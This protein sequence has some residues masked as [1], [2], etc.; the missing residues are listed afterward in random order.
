MADDPS[1]KSKLR[2]WPIPSLSTIAAWA[3]EAVIVGLSMA[4]VVAD[5]RVAYE[6]SGTRYLWVSVGLGVALLSANVLLAVGCKAV[7]H[8]LGQENVVQAQRRSRI[9]RV[10][11]LLP[12][13]SLAMRLARHAAF[14]IVA[15]A[16]PVGTWGFLKVRWAMQ[17]DS[18]SMF[19]SKNNC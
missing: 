9:A 16:S 17:S 12:T 11:S 1:G 7:L 10:R 14:F 18:R 4:T 8:D 13:P 5:V 3:G 19:H 2:M 15:P 6:F